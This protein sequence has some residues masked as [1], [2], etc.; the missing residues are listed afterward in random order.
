MFTSPSPDNTSTASWRTE[1][2]DCAVCGK[3]LR[4]GDAVTRGVE[5]PHPA[6][7]NPTNVDPNLRGREDWWRHVACSKEGV[8]RWCREN[9][10]GS[11]PL[12]WSRESELNWTF[13]AAPPIRRGRHVHRG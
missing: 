12:T 4:M 2:P 6:A 7:S 11:D 3:E 10:P 5:A 13:F 8:E 1:M 9:R